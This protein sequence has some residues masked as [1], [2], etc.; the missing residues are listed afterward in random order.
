MLL[1]AALSLLFS[2]FFPYW[3]LKVTA[4]QYPKGLRVAIFVNHLE[5]DVAEI[6]SLNH[7]I[8]MRSLKEGAKLERAVSIPGIA[9][10]CSCLIATVLIRRKASVILLLPGIIFPGI[11]AA[12]LYLWLRDFGLHLNP[13]AALSSSIKPFVPPILGQGK[14]AQFHAYANFAFGHGLSMLASF[15]ALGAA[16][17]RL[18]P[19]ENSSKRGPTLP[20]VLILFC[21]WNIS[22]VYAAEFIVGPA[23]YATIQEA[24]EAST[25]G[26]TI[27]VKP[28]IYSGPVAVH[29]S[30]KLIGVDMPV[31]DAGGKGTVV[32]LSAPDILFK[33]FI[34]RNGGDLLSQENS[35]I[36]A[37]AKHAQIEENR[38][39]NVLFG[40]YLNRSANSVV[41]NN[42]LIGKQLD[43]ARRGDLIRVWYSD[44]VLIEGNKTSIG[45]DVVLWYSKNIQVVGN[46]FEWARYGLHFMYCQSAVVEKNK[47]IGNSVGAYM[48]YSNDLILK[49]NVILNNRG[50]SGYGIGFKDMTRAH[51]ENNVIASNRVGLFMDGSAEGKISRNLVAYNDIG[52]E[53]FP[54][55]HHNQLSANNVMDNTEQ[56]TMD[57]STAYTNNDWNGNHWSDYRGFDVNKDGIGDLAYK[58]LKFFERLM[59]R[60]HVM[61]IF[62]MS[63]S[64]HAIDFASAAFP[65][66]SPTEKLTD[67]QPLMSPLQINISV[68]AN[69]VSW[70]WILTSLIL[71]IPLIGF[72]AV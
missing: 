3:Y 23:G 24:L 72:M 1:L 18:F 2:I 61:K 38:I 52:F 30:V 11:F 5:G 13:H 28:G 43:V 34:V 56:V 58:P 10:I 48:M 45:R 66:F 51:V 44:D 29:K 14:V 70:A 57:S 68:P 17:L 71:L 41:R 36:V 8:G 15:L 53:I 55:V 60:S 33:G 6:D 20:V 12:D 32:K 62:F 39:E 65:I 9:I 19:K 16:M 49:E 40:I 46:D 67:A 63:P 26:D 59:D 37:T 50:P 25:N 54:T 35:G 22:S 42:I 21:F 27:V 4:P 31:I 69:P 7:Y 64:V 47:L